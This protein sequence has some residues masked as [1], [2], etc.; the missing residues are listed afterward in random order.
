MED[1]SNIFGEKVPYAHQLRAHAETMTAIDNG[2]RAIVVTAPARSGKTAMMAMMIDEAKRRQWPVVLYTHRILLTEQTAEKFTD[3]NIEFGIR[4]AGWEPALLRDVQIASVWTEASRVLRKGK[5]ELHHGKLIL[6]DEGHLMGGPTVTKI[7]RQHLKDGAIVITYTATP[8]DMPSIYETMIIAAKNSELRA[9]GIHVPCLIYSGTEPDLKHV[10]RLSTGEFSEP[11][12]RKAFRLQQIFGHIYE[13]WEQLNPKHEPGVLFACGVPESRW[14]VEELGKKGV[15]AAH[16]DADSVIFNARC[17]K[18]SGEEFSGHEARRMRSEVLAMSSDGALPLISNRYILREAIDCPHWKFCVAA[19][20]F[21]SITSYLQACSRVLTSHPGK[22]VAVLQDH[23]GSAFRFGSINADQE[24][25]LGMTP[26]Q[27]ND[28]YKQQIVSGETQECHRCPQCGLLRGPAWHSSGKCPGCGFAYSKS[29]RPVLQVSGE[30]KMVQGSYF[31][32]RRTD[33]RSDV[34]K[35]WEKMY[36]RGVKS[37]MSFAQMEA[38]FAKENSWSWP[39]RSL[40]LQPVNAADWLRRA[41]DVPKMRLRP[42]PVA[43]N[44]GLFDA[45][46]VASQPKMDF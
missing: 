25:E 3:A 8:V 42:M 24:W 12:L 36:Y 43:D 18:Y 7:L 20:A 44:N 16:I 9:A 30:L 46:S 22:E 15:A 31:G 40:G 29:I 2:F 45:K 10:K 34:Q 14:I 17:T 35:R 33:S 6:V 38:L 23:G 4:A 11:S 39:P 26:S 27:A 37:G 13:N 32:K 21:G 19:T 5:R 1:W 28:L 41:K